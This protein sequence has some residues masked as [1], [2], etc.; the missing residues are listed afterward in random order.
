MK[1]KLKIVHRNRD[2]RIFRSQLVKDSESASDRL[3]N[4]LLSK[5]IV[6]LEGDTVTVEVV[7][8]KHEEGR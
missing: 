6:L 7:E 8:D 3:M 5:D 4:M 1:A 2:G